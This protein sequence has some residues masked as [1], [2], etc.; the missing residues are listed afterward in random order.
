M[1]QDSAVDKLLGLDPET[2]IDYERKNQCDPEFALNPRI[3][4]SW[5]G[6]ASNVLNTSYQDLF[7]LLTALNLPAG[8][9]VVDLGSGFGRLGL[10]I[11]L[12]FAGLEFTGVECWQHRLQ[13]AQEIAKKMQMS[14]VHFEHGDLL[15]G[16]YQIPEADIYFSYLTSSDPQSL[17]SIL[18]KLIQTHNRNYF[19]LVTKK[20]APDL[21]NRLAPSLSLLK[22]HGNTLGP[23]FIYE[24]NPISSITENQA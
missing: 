22:T 1:L 23:F 19:R 10:V 7:D 12:G 16:D 11:G 21:M 15:S 20:V 13:A 2:V 14:N 9:R 18:E 6:L 8:T 4:D 5:V 24:H 3:R 17:K